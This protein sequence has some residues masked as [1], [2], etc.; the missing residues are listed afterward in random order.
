MNTKYGIGCLIVAGAFSAAATTVWLENGG[1]DRLTTGDGLDK[2][3][4]S[5]VTANVVEIPGLSITART[6]TDMLEINALSESFGIINK[7]NPED[8]RDC[9]D[10]DESMLLSF[11]K[12]VTLSGI[13]FNRFDK[14]ESFT[15]QIGAENHVITYKALTNKSSD[16][17]RCDLNVPAKTEIRLSTTGNSIIGLDALELEVMDEP[18]STVE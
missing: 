17:F 1:K 7:N 11:N 12:A 9:F 5:T 18:T 4:N 16:I 8:N 15:I 13:D 14:D 10:K 2:I 6:T 3:K